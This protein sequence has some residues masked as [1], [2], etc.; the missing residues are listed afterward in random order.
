LSAELEWHDGDFASAYRLNRAAVHKMPGS[1]IAALQNTDVE[2]GWLI[3]AETT[4]GGFTENNLY[5]RNEDNTAWDIVGLKSHSHIDAESGG[6]MADVDIANVPVTLEYNKRF[7]RANSYWSTIVSTGTI[8][9]DA[10]NGCVQLQSGTTSG[11]SATISDGGA[12]KLNFAQ[13][14]ALEVTL[15]V[16]S[17]TNFQ[18]KLGVR[19]EDINGGNLSPV[20]YGIEGC[21]SSGTNWLLFSS[22][23]TA[24]ST[25]ATSAPVATGA[26]DVYRLEC[27]PGSSL[28]F[29][30]NGTLVATK[31]LNVP[32]TGTT[33]LNDLYRAGIKNSA[34][35][36]KILRH[37]GAIIVGGI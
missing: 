5:Q 9:D 21:S 29:Y 25:V 37:Y 17:A 36:N 11:G 19:A 23:G 15:E 7:A 33:G 32:A 12:R 20:K 14:S 4:G 6:T 34:A 10:T 8:T 3:Y 28:T 13:P 27:E 26:A 18:V 1:S 22:D 16:T 2:P 31:T 35:E 30:K 24:R